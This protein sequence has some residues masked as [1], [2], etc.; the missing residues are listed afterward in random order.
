[1][2]EPNPPTDPEASRERFATCHPHG[3]REGPT[4][5]SVGIGRKESR[6]SSWRRWG[7][8]SEALL[9]SLE[10]DVQKR[11]RISVYTED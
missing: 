8:F 4:F 9:K 3:S 1:M 7:V 2:R 11:L 10:N 6:P 5:L